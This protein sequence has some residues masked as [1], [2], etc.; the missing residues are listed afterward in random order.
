MASTDDILLRL[1]IR[2]MDPSEVKRL[3]DQTYGQLKTESA[4][5]IEELA[6][7]HKQKS[8]EMDENT[9]KQ[10]DSQI[11]AQQKLL[12]NVQQLMRQQE[13]EVNRAA[14]SWDRWLERMENITT[15][16]RGVFDAVG[17]GLE[18]FHNL[19]E[20]IIRT[21]QIYNSLTGSIEEMRLATEGEVSNI[22][23]IAAKNRGQQK[24]L[25]LTDQQYGLVAASAKR[26]ADAIGI[27]TKD[28]LDQL[29][30]GLATG[31]TK[32]LQHAGIIIDVAEANEKWA[33]S[34]GLTVDA[35]T[36]QNKLAALQEE[37][38]RKMTEKMDDVADHSDK[39]ANRMERGWARLKNIMTDTAAAIGN[40]DVSA[41]TGGLDIGDNPTAEGRAFRERQAR[42]RAA[43]EAAAQAAWDKEHTDFEDSNGIAND[44]AF[45]SP[46]SMGDDEQAAR[47]KMKHGDSKGAKAAEDARKE[48]EVH[49]RHTLQLIQGWAKGIDDWD[50]EQAELSKKAEEAAKKV[51]EAA[52]KDDA[53]SEEMANRLAKKAADLQIKM[54]DERKKLLGE[55]ADKAGFMGYFLW[56]TDGP[57]EVYAE[58]DSFGK[59]MVDV[60]GTTS[61]AMEQAGKKLANAVGASLAAYVSGTH[62]GR[63][64]LRQMTHDVLENL[65]AQAF[66]QALFEGAM[67]LKDLAI[68]NYPGAALHG[69]AALAFAAVGGT[70]GLAARAVG[71]PMQNAADQKAAE[72]AAKQADRSGGVST[73]GSSFGSGGQRSSAGGGDR[74]PVVI[75]LN[76]VIGGAET[77]RAVKKALE[78][79]Q[80]LT[81]EQLLGQAA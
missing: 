64:A 69:T 21:T 16:M 13:I 31:R 37:A 11:K 73:S 71:N 19:S 7:L 51:D 43:V 25:Q 20:E 8:Q 78:E 65:S 36:E 75:N 33:K 30:D 32:M 67:A 4:K 9:K 81:G 63:L 58:M 12:Q 39:L 18:R 56:G 38:L 3:A 29:I 35:M 6:R 41:V 62:S 2:G 23:L 66:A 70:V 40:L 54:E 45:R 26:Y 57:D 42:R 28:A 74:P 68:G 76:G 5:H 15:V 48:A 77:G 79:Y 49:M 34:A 72:A 14:A 27:N 1:V 80:N 17:G 44:N 10:V 24:E 52:A 50:K 22:D 46:I 61:T 59:A 47:G 60:M 53:S 55:T